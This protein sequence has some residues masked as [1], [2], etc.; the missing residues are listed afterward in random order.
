MAEKKF[1]FEGSIS[2]EAPYIK[3]KAFEDLEK[4]CILNGVIDYVETYKGYT[5]G[6]VLINGH[7]TRIILNMSLNEAKELIGKPIKLK[8]DG[9]NTE[10][11]PDL[12]VRW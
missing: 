11:Y 2:E 10:G 1:T 9:M 7:T 12:Y 6:A 5:M 3:A 4:G 8:F